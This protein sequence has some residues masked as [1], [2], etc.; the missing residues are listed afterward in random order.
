MAGMVWHVQQHSIFP[1]DDLPLDTRFWVSHAACAPV[2]ACAGSKD[3]AVGVPVAWLVEEES[4]VAA[5]KGV[6]P[7]G[8]FTSMRNAL[9]CHRYTYFGHVGCVN[10][11]GTRQM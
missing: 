4:E 10:C 5:F 9:A 8:R 6:S 1:L 11:Y 2:G 3:V 7:G